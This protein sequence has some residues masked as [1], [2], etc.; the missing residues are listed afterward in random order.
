MAD[1]ASIDE[2][3][4]GRGVID[5]RDQADKRGLTG[6][7]RSDDSQAGAGR[8]AQVDVVQN[9]SAVIGEV[10]IAKFNLARRS[11]IG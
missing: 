5:A 9:S 3:G 7:G 6:A 2:D 1:G 11:V 10:Q 4:S 8:D